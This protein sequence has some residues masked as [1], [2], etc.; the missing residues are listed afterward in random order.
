MSTRKSGYMN[1]YLVSISDLT[2]SPT[3]GRAG[4]ET[5]KAIEVNLCTLKSIKIRLRLT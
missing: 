5:S 2:T 3:T 4:V 1:N